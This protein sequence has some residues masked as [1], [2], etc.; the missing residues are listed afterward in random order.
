MLKR[1][2]TLWYA[3]VEKSRSLK[4]HPAKVVVTAVKEMLQERQAEGACLETSRRQQWR[5]KQKVLNF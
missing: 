3:M 4:G 2:N 5:R 1:K